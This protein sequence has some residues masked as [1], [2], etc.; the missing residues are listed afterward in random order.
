MSKQFN[1]G[2]KVTHDFS[3][4]EG[5]VVGLRVLKPYTV[6]VQWGTFFKAKKDWYDPKVLEHYA[7]SGITLDDQIDHCLGELVN[8]YKHTHSFEDEPEKKARQLERNKKQYASAKETLKGVIERIKQ[9]AYEEG[10]ADCQDT[11]GDGPSS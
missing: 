9:E 1:L 11:Y 4:G 8:Q 10:Y 7:P 3:G 5:R 2:D 6:M